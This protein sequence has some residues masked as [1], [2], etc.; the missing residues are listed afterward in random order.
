MQSLGQPPGAQSR[1]EKWPGN[2]REET[3]I[4]QYTLTSLVLSTAL[5]VNPLIH[6]FA[7][8]ISE[9]KCGLLLE[10]FPDVPGQSFPFCLFGS[11]EHF[12]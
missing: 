4:T 9:L 1:Q 2:L 5:P 11:F 6:S 7:R 3:E 8:F 10:A 12:L